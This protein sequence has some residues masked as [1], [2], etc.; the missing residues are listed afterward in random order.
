MS[1]IYDRLPFLTKAT[2]PSQST[3][4]AS[5]GTTTGRKRFNEN[6][7]NWK[8]LLK[9]VEGVG[10]TND[11][12]NYDQDRA[13]YQLAA[14]IAL[15]YD[16]D[17]N[18]KDLSDTDNLKGLIDSIY[19]ERLNGGINPATMRGESDPYNAGSMMISGAKKGLDAFNEGIGR[20]IDAAGD[21][22]G[23]G[24]VEAT[25][26]KEA[27]DRWRNASD[28]REYAWIPSV[29]E[30]LALSLIPGF[31]IPLTMAKNAVED[32][33]K[34][35]TAATGVDPITLQQYDAN[36]RLMDLGSAALD[37]G[38]SALPGFGTAAKGVAKGGKAAGKL[39]QEAEDAAT[40]LGSDA[41]KGAAKKMDDIAA[42]NAESE[43]ALND[44]LK[45]I[46]PSTM[47]EDELV[48]LVNARNNAKLMAQTGNEEAV[49]NAI[50]QLMDQADEIR[51][52]APDVSRNP[53]RNVVNYARNADVAAP[54]TP[55]ESIRARM[56]AV[57]EGPQNILDKVLTFLRGEAADDSA[58][59]A[60]PFETKSGAK[61]IANKARKE[62]RESEDV[63]KELEAARAETLER[64]GENDN[65]R[66]ALRAALARNR[67][68]SRTFGPTPFEKPNVPMMLAQPI[69][70]TVGMASDMNTDIN[71]AL[72]N[73]GSGLQSGQISPG[74]LL[75]MGIPGPKR[76]VSKAFGSP[77]YYGSKMRGFNQAMSTQLNQGGAVDP[78]TLLAIQL[79]DQ[80]FSM[81]E[82]RNIMSQGNG[83]ENGEQ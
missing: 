32:S 30:D 54:R 82:I 21:F 62:G 12:R 38:L 20:G 63:R 47:D 58:A 15:G 59:I 19:T 36:D 4:S 51:N 34:L 60:R 74:V 24:I 70:S 17:E 1:N 83:G 45:S 29:A 68:N 10:E 49:D 55:A 65:F 72:N 13:K 67:A 25:Q 44:R 53:F 42:R 26:G 16:E 78:N 23:G 43:K 27:A 71:T 2:T 50:K 76:A 11:G 77:A 33:D 5:T 81:E 7:H 8:N 28:G 64:T 80:G 14:Q 69:V 40:D 56:E 35:Y 3:P 46:D 66:T 75:A 79:M 31:G 37:I 73:L 6:D 48:N 52:S 57:N 9:S 61:K 18:G 39:A 41:V 22:I